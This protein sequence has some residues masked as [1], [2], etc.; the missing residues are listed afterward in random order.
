MDNK[1]NIVTTDQKSTLEDIVPY[2]DTVNPNHLL[3]EIESIIRRFIVCND[4]TVVA[5][6]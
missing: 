1:K 5:T 2:N 6:V 4:E 3:L